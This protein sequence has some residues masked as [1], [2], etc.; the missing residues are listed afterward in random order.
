MIKRSLSLLLLFA[1]VAFAQQESYDQ[2]LRHWDYDHKAPLAVQESGVQDR[3]GI[4]VHDLSYAVPT[5]DRAASLGPNGGRVTA[6]LVVPPGKG[7]FPAVIYGHWCMPGSEM[8]NR[9]EF[10]DEAVVLARSGVIA[11]LPDHVIARP[12]FEQSKEPLNTQ[13]IDVLVQQVTNMRRGADLLLAR[14]D[15]DAKRL[16]YAGHSCN[17]EVGGF[18]SGI[19]KRFKA[20]VLMAGPLSDE[21]TNK[22]P[23]YQA[24]R[25]KIGPE[26]FDAFVAKYAW[27]DP[28]K[29]V[30]HSEGTPK[31]LQFG[32]EE[33]FLVPERAKQYL[34]YVSEPK[35]LKIYEAPHA[36]NAEATRDRLSFLARELGVKTPDAKLI[37]A[38]PPLVQP[39][40]P[41]PPGATDEKKDE[42]KDK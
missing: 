36:L 23:V 25:Q 10:L 2:L 15:V 41:K 9:T 40:W 11:L 26:K 20:V 12:G 30:S 37:A 39:P 42:K 27:T 3:D 13:Q 4:K 16:A 38:I 7:P 1:S 29:Y 8:L 31:L 33:P 34:A 21:V 35:T 32:T 6:Y 28:G 22:A 14:K 18:L 19:D 5:G 24:Y 17:A